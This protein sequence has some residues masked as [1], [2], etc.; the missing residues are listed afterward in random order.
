GAESWDTVA[1]LSESWPSTLVLKGPFT[2]IARGG[3]TW[4]HTLPNP[5]LGTG[6]TGDVLTGIIGGL[7]SRGLEPLQAAQLGVWTHGR[8]GAAGTA[9]LSFPRFSGPVRGEDRRAPA[10]PASA[11]TI[12]PSKKL[13][14]GLPHPLPFGLPPP[15]EK[16]A[17]T[18]R[19]A[20]VTAL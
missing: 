12:K 14:I 6:G 3:E 11:P 2:A 17:S 19:R 9:S 5:A 1:R 18:K 16:N 10:A 7:L 8:A 4:V 13:P 20:P 15:R